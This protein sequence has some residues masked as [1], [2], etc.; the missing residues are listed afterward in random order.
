[1]YRKILHVWL[2]I[3]PKVI[4]AQGL[5]I[6]TKPSELVVIALVRGAQMKDPNRKVG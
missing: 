4:S 5:V 6:S 3:G 2:L 1:M